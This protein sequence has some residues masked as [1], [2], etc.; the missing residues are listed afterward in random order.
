MFAVIFALALIVLQLILGVVLT[1][2]YTPSS[3]VGEI[4][5]LSSKVEFGETSMVSQVVI[6]LS[7]LGITIGVTKL[8]N[9][10]IVR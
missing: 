1:I 10:K 7:A 9:K 2:S 4:T 8:S 6:A 5:A 3:S